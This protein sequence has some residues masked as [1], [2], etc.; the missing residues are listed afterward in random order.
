M[1][2]CSMA[3]TALVLVVLGISLVERVPA[4]A[5]RVLCVMITPISWSG[6]PD[7]VSQL[8]ECRS[9]LSH[10]VDLAEW[11]GKIICLMQ[12]HSA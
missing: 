8:S 4:C 10:F 12:W 6:Q 3:A 9:E 2:A 5:G 1:L 11:L 7:N